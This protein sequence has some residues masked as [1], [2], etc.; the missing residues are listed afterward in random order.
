MS[1][2][3]S[4]KLSPTDV[5]HHLACQHRSQL[6]R[7]V[8]EG[9]LHVDFSPDARLA[10]MRERGMKHEE[11]YVNKLR[12]EARRVVDLRPSNDP[13]DTY[14]EMIKGTDVIIQAP[15]GAGSFFGYADVMVKTPANSR[16][17]PWSYEPIDTKLAAETKAGAILQ[18]LTYCELLEHMQGRRP[19]QFR[20]VTPLA[21][22]TY[23]TADYAAYFRVIRDQLQVAHSAEP[24]PATYPEPVPHCDVCNFWEL[25]ARRRR[26]DDHP[27]LI[28]GAGRGQVR[29]LQTQGLPTVKALAE[30]GR[31]PHKPSFGQAGTYERLAHQARLQVAARTSP[32]VPVERLP[33]SPGFGLSKLPEPSTGDVFLD[34]EG[35]PFVGP[36]GLEYLTGF[37]HLDA[38]GRF[39]TQQLWALDHAAEKTAVQRFLDFLSDRLTTYSD[40]HVYHFGA[41]EVAA[42]RR[43]C[44]R[45]DTH[46]EVLDLLLRG[47]RFVDLHRVV[48]EGLRIGIEGYGLKELEPVFGF[49]RQLALREAGVARRDLELSLELQRGAIPDVLRQKVAAYNEDDC[50]ATASLR[51]WLEQQRA[52]AISSGHEVLRPILRAGEAREAVREKDAR[53]Q[54]LRDALLTGLPAAGERTSVQKA[55]AL[56]GD[57]VGYFRREDK[58]AWWEHFRLREVPSENRFDERD[59][60]ADMRF[61]RIEPNVGRQRAVRCAYHYPPQ[62]STLEVGKSVY[63]VRDEDPAKEGIGT[64]LGMVVAVDHD[65]QRIVIQHRKDAADL[66]PTA[67]FRALVVNSKVIEDALLAFAEHVRDNGFD[68]AGS[69]G[70]ASDLLLRVAPW[71]GTAGSGTLRIEGEDSVSAA[72]R[73]CRGLDGGVL[74]VQG[75]PGTG[76]SHTGGHTISALAAEAKVGVTAV[77]H[78]VIDN[79][80][81]ATHKASEKAGRAVRLLHKHEGDAPEGIEYT[82]DNGEALDS[83]KSGTVV[84]GTA[85]LWAREEAIDSLDYLFVDEAGQMSLAQLLAIARCAKNLVLL[86]DP[87]Q[88]EQPQKGAH[89]DGADVA[90]LTYLIGTDRQTL[91]DHQGLFLGE[92]YRL[93]P[94]LCDFTSEIYYESRLRPHP[95]LANQR[96]E[97]TGLVDGSG[98]F[99]LPC[100]HDGNQSTAAEEV[101]A[102]HAL[103]QRILVPGARWTDRH[104]KTHPLTADDVRVIAPYNAQVAALRRAL[105]PLG[106]T[107]VGTVDKFQGQEA[108]LV[109]YSCTSSSPEDA[110]R[111]LAFLYDPH[112]LNVATSRARCAFV[113]VANP[114]LFM[115]DV[116]TPEQMR[117]A[118]GMCRF[119]EVAHQIMI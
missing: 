105:A 44:S 28:A 21:E 99:L 62:E 41:Y 89:P 66:R 72:I 15:L 76:K 92:T 54:A 103:L 10:A 95:D 119:R 16:L 56:L 47:E 55:R 6:Q 67:V 19:A 8:R 98:H 64:E 59:M 35:D 80:L 69:Y 7:Q 37:G 63:L 109:I 83:I 65:Q 58:S 5:A 88:L 9:R 52:A 90:A 116:R 78:K 115:P 33:V 91:A 113:M 30:A 50:R 79:L 60:L 106:V 11:E 87:Q 22:E 34:F 114:R 40:L 117:M 38:S 43:L 86:G 77:S 17:G 48:K 29:E 49:R 23:R 18:L 94:P 24:P 96:I 107:E 73:L 53:V 97:G 57:L 20:V 85:W 39:V 108:P 51:D 2:N 81:K 111:G 13:K 74:P 61:D 112:R 71:G 26:D 1:N 118:N 14:A 104:R 42:L 93:A 110:P 32:T 36:S 45:H 70:R 82:E 102:V 25:C 12:A 75:P 31:L 84:G 46:G 100:E 68:A 3:N 101:K 27:S 4:N